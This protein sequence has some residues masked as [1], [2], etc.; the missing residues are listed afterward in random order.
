ME[1]Q[2][3]DDRHFL[4]IQIFKRDKNGTTIILTR[5]S[6]KACNLIQNSPV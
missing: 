1:A 2:T 6:F 4:I 5:R 3:F